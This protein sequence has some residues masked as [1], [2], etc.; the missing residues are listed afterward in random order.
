[1]IKQVE[2]LI[3]IAEKEIGVKENPPNSNNVKYNTWYYRNV[4]SGAGLAWCCA[5]ISWLFA[6]T[7]FSELF[8]GGV[9]ENF[10]PNVVSYAKRNNQWFTSGYK[11]GDIP[12]FDWDGTRTRA[13][14]IGLI[15]DVG[16]GYVQTIEGNTAITNQDNG[17]A[18][19]RRTR[20][21]A[22]ITGVYRP[23]YAEGGLSMDE[24]K[25]LKAL[26]EALTAKVE[27]RDVIVDKL[28]ELVKELTAE[29]AE[30]TKR[31]A[32]IYKTIDDIPDW[33]GWKESVRNAID[34]GVTNGVEQDENGE[35]INLGL[36]WAEVRGLVMADRREV[37]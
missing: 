5:F 36:S 4:V 32:P 31:H 17:G 19:M 26:I 20:N 1:M 37:V 7:D 10:C 3:A 29:V 35:I 18:V 28:G 33:P 15:T 9:R 23:T 14:H 25:E 22:L 24:Y 21:T 27:K 11:R 12:I 16:N 8:M 34:K 30:L 2:N 6:Q 13:Q